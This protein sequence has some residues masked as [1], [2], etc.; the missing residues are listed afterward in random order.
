MQQTVS[1]IFSAEFVAVLSQYSRRTKSFP[2]FIFVRSPN[3]RKISPRTPICLDF[4][5]PI[6]SQAYLTTDRFLFKWQL[7]CLIRPS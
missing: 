7:P 2:I 1:C 5:I 4:E 6:G 3:F